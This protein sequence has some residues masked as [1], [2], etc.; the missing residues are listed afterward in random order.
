[1]ILPLEKQLVSREL[2]QEMKELGFPQEG[3]FTYVENREGDG[4]ELIQ[5]PAIK[6]IR[7]SASAYSVAELGMWLPANMQLPFKRPVM[8]EAKEWSECWFWSNQEG[9]N[10][11]DTEANARASMLIYLAKNKLI[12]VK[13]LSN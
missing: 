11:I 9:R 3:L 5:Y 6:L 10:K 4:W 8:N 2:A 7:E 12:D 1:M 13:Q